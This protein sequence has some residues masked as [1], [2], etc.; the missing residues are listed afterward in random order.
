MLSILHSQPKITHS[1]VGLSLAQI[2][3]QLNITTLHIEGMFYPST[4]F[5]RKGTSDRQILQQALRQMQ[6][7][8]D[9][10]WQNRS[11][12]QPYANA[13]E[14][15]IAASLVE[16][17]TANDKERYLI[18]SVIANRLHSKMLLQ[19]DP[20][21]IYGM[22]G[23]FLGR[24]LRSDLKFES[25]YNTYLYPGLP[26]SPIA[27]ASQKSIHAVLHPAMTNYLYYV[28]NKDGT[29]LFAT[30]LKEHVENINTVKNQNLLDT[31][32]D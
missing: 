22:G 11:S 8:I 2:R 10:E 30:N 14:A 5:F 29:H 7:V 20:A 4:Y 23:H 12:S 16:K 3:Q 26:P 13:Y 9:E 17:E 15:L 19:I 6:R 1:L 24:L 31:K 18:A 21:V 32:H 28:S 27:L 25:P